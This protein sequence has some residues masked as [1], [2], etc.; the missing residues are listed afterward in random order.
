MVVRSFLSR[1]YWFYSKQ[2]ELSLLFV[3]PLWLLYEA[4]AYQLND[5]WLGNLRTGIDFLIKETFNIVGLHPGLSVLIAIVLSGFYFQRKGKNI[6]EYTK[7]PTVFALMFLESLAY[8]VVFGLIVGW[9]TGWFLSQGSQQVDEAKLATL[10]VSIGSG[11]YEEIVFRFGLIVGL[12]SIVKKRVQRNGYPFWIAVVLLSALLF[13]G[14]HY[15]AFFDEAWSWQSFTFRFMA[16]VALAILFIY[17]GFG[18]TTYT[19]SLYNIL[20]MFR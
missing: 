14:F 4:L 8:A 1:E 15:L 18:V 10:I 9:V 17:R 5:G 19:H 13:A 12:I 20:L 7:K 3:A 11:P 16:G 2:H 6:R